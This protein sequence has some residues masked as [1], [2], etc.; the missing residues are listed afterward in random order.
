MAKELDTAI[1]EGRYYEFNNII[2][3]S[4]L[5]KMDLKGLSGPRN[6]EFTIDS[7]SGCD[8]AHLSKVGC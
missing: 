3:T 2:S 4:R 8:V 6:V 7:L 1:T 5:E